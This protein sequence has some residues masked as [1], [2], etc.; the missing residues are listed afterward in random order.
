[1][2]NRKT[3]TIHYPIPRRQPPEITSLAVAAPIDA[4][5]GEND[6]GGG[7]RIVRI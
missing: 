6:P 5:G 7:L 3:S 4:E 1:M 2:S